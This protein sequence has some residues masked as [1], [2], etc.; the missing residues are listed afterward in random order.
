MIRSALWVWIFFCLSLPLPA[1]ARMT[2]AL[3]VLCAMGERCVIQ[4][5][6]DRD[7]GPEYRDYQCGSLSYDGH[8]GTD[9]R[10]KTV[11]V[12]RDGV[13]VVAAARGKVK[14]IRDGVE[15][16]DPSGHL[17]LEKI[18][19]RPAGNGVLLDHGNGWETQYSHLR[20]GSVQVVPGQ[21]VEAG[22]KL[23]LIGQSGMAAFPHLHFEVR[24]HGTPVDPFAFTRQPLCGA[25][26]D[27]LWSASAKKSLDYR[28]S[29]ELSSGFA[30]QVPDDAFVAHPP[31]QP[32]SGWS[33]APAL[34]FWVNLFGVRNHDR[35]TIRLLDP[36]GKIL[37]EQSRTHS[38]HRARSM[39]YIGKK[40][41]SADHHWPAGRYSGEYTLFRDGT[42]QPIL[43]INKQLMIPDDR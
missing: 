6:L 38:K 33:T 39:S 21:E 13:A 37:A 3:P 28:P 11:Q 32:D 41:P 34:L 35:E 26:N 20:R 29:G 5:Y 14:A 4:N 30:H 16:G 27:P 12:M 1:E 24:L 19:D 2:F 42:D 23:G 18:G 9:F 25:D 31:L 10:V 8:Q 22:E 43:Q 40:A 7:P 17:N 36:S 15:D